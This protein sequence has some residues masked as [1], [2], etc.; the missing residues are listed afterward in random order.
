MAAA[1]RGRMSLTRGGGGAVVLNWIGRMGEVG[2]G[3]ESMVEWGVT[4]QNGDDY[5]K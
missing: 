1:A 5:I 2:S 4:R 3:E